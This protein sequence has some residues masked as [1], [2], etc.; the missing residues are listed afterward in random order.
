MIGE[1]LK[2]WIVNLLPEPEPLS[3]KWPSLLRCIVSVSNNCGPISFLHISSLCHLDSANI[4]SQ[5]TISSLLF[6]EHCTQLHQRTNY[7]LISSSLTD[8]ADPSQR[9]RRAATILIS[10]CDRHRYI[11]MSLPGSSTRAASQRKRASET[12]S[13]R[14]AQWIWECALKL[15]RIA[16]GGPL[17]WC[18]FQSHTDVWGADRA[19]IN[20]AS[21]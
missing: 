9:G 6:N 12:N 4:H 21:W 7:Y 14:V 1:D 20:T 8:W 11:F 18:C 16:M 3:V 17:W 2:K 10:I 5:P 13:Q 19:E 15:G